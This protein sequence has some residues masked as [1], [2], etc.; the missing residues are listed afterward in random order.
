[1]K[2][3]K[4]IAFTVFL[5]LAFSCGREKTE[6]RFDFDKVGWKKFDNLKFSVDNF[7][8]DKLYGISLELLFDENY[9]VKTFDFQLLI[10]NNDGESWNKIFSLK[11]RDREGKLKGEKTR[12]NKYRFV[13][14]LVKRK[15]FH[16]KARY[17]FT[18]V[19]LNPKIITE[20]IY[21][22]ALKI[23]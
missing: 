4:K 14:T 21:S 19:N 2:V 6:Y 13:S 17:D 7:D 3:M 1:M 16:E 20:G 10:D 23:Q 12:D 9:K 5:I 8:P 22:L 18:I 11:V 15:Y